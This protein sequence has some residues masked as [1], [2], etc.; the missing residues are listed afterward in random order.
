MYIQHTY[1]PNIT[2]DHKSPSFFQLMR[3][4]I[5][6]EVSSFYYKMYGPRPELSMV[7]AKSK[8]MRETK[9]PHP[10]SIN[11]HIAWMA[12]APGTAPGGPGRNCRNDIH[13]NMQTRFFCGFHPDCIDICSAAAI[14]RA[15]EVLEHE[16][17][18]VGLL[19]D[20][21]VTLVTLEQMLPSMLTGIWDAYHEVVSGKLSNKKNRVGRASK[22]EQPTPENRQV[23]EQHHK[24]DVE[25]YRF[26]KELFRVRTS[27]C[28]TTRKSTSMRTFDET[29]NLLPVRISN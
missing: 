19:E 10:P 20:L 24:Q 14:K 21:E 27:L 12:K 17:M 1:W 8:F 26:A 2:S 28:N 3:E 5:A 25:L 9:L 4:P 23:L 11:E 13:G 6:R 29:T 22:M 16:Y 18:F 15:K 7:K